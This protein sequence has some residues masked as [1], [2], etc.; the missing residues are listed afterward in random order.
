MASALGVFLPRIVNCFCFNLGCFV[1]SL[2]F[3]LSYYCHLKKKLEL[4]F[5]GR[6]QSGHASPNWL[7]CKT[8]LGDREA[9]TWICH[10]QSQVR[11]TSRDWHR[12]SGKAEGRQKEGGQWKGG[13]LGGLAWGGGT[14]R[15]QHIL[16]PVLSLVGPSHMDSCQLLH[17]HGFE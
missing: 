5:N 2:F 9:S 1:F 16:E 11:L 12:G 17:W 6:I 4:I 8:T 14:A 7:F 13:P 3:F 15:I 10:N